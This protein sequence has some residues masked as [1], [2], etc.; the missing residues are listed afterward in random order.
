MVIILYDI[1]KILENIAV[2]N[3]RKSIKELMNI[4]PEYANLLKENNLTKVN[5]E[6]VKVGDTIVIKPGEKI[7]LDGVITKGN[8]KLNTQSLTGE[9]KLSAVSI[10]DKVLSGTINIESSFGHGCI[11]KVVVPIKKED[12]DNGN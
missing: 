12:N 8:S 9:S 4:K 11:V 1:G 7:P 10:N 5:P 3:S 6:L 2:N